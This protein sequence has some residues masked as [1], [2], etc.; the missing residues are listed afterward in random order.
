MLD[1]LTPEITG[2]TLNEGR[3][4]QLSARD[5][6]AEINCTEAFGTGTNMSSYDLKGIC[7]TFFLLVNFANPG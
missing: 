1:S 2:M 5:Q 3:A 6:V 4:Q 7:C